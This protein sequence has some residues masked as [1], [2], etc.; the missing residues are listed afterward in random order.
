MCGRFTLRTPANVLTEQLLRDLGVEAPASLRP[1]YNAAPTQ[2][3]AVVRESPEIARE[4]PEAAREFAMLRWGLIPSWAKDPSIGNR[5]INARG[6]TVAEKPAFRA[7]FRR[8]RCLIPA[9]GFFEWK[10]IG[11]QKQ[12]YYFRMSD[13][14]PFAFA[15]LWECWAGDGD[16]A[17]ESCTIITT[18]ANDLLRPFHDRMPVILSPDDFSMWLDPQFEDKEQLQRLLRPYTPEEMTAC[19]VNIRV[20]SPKHD[21]PQCVE[22]A[23]E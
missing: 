13:E 18:E 1:R 11:K 14:R 7:A 10:K 22:I 19:P 23:A 2:S 3:I 20:N 8:R 16:A 12:P 5:M 9:D 17:L 15:G 4:S 6:E 21:D